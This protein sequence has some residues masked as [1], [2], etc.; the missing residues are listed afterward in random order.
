MTAIHLRDA[1]ESANLTTNVHFDP[2]EPYHPRHP[3]HHGGYAPQ[4][5]YQPPR[6]IWERP[7][8][9]GVPANPQQEAQIRNTLKGYVAQ[10]GLDPAIVDR[11]QIQFT[12]GGPITLQKTGHNTYTLNISPMINDPELGT[13]ILAHEAAHY[14]HY[15]GNRNDSHIPGARQQAEFEADEIAYRLVGPEVAFRALAK[16][17]LNMSMR[18]TSMPGGGISPAQRIRNL[19]QKFGVNSGILD[20]RGSL[21]AADME[22]EHAALKP[23][24]TPDMRP[25][26]VMGKAV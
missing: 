10:L 24:A 15:E 20:R 6:S 14:T 1:L 17:H 23:L 19:E 13:F 2:Y 5:Q 22:T 7:A 11:T 9:Q 18:N 8:P 26:E 25:E 4:P 16:E 3:H 21:E 12:G